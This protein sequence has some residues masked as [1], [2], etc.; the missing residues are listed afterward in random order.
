M[1]IKGLAF[2]IHWAQKHTVY[3]AFKSTLAKTVNP[4]NTYMHTRKGISY[5]SRLFTGFIR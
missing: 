5:C 4:H 3:N 1:E 2:G